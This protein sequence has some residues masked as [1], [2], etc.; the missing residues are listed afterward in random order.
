MS[1]NSKSLMN[2]IASQLPTQGV[3]MQWD[4]RGEVSNQEVVEDNTLIA[5]CHCDT[6][7]EM[8]YGN[9]TQELTCNLTGQVMLNAL[10]INDLD[11]EVQ[12]LFDSLAKLVKSFRYTEANGPLILDGICSNVTTEIDNLYYTFNIEFTLHVQF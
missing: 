8:I 3:Q 12:S 7:R 5:V 9:F 2:Y 6:Q 11:T 10:S 4:I 1:N